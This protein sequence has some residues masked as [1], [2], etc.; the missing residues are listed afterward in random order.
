M[1]PHFIPCIFLV[2]NLA[3][4]HTLVPGEGSPFPQKIKSRLVLMKFS[5]PCG[6]AL[7]ALS[8]IWSLRGLF[9]DGEMNPWDTRNDKVNKLQ[10][11]C[12]QVM[13]RADSE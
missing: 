1:V 2:T 12:H 7:W 10:D 13:P 11:P 5:A 4:G 8:C 9:S 6:K 3:E